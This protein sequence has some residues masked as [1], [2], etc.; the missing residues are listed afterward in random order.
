L[1]AIRKRTVDA[2]GAAASAEREISDLRHLARQESEQIDQLQDD[3]GP[4]AGIDIAKMTPRR[5]KTDI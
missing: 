5:D 1:P 3:A 4:S 2:W